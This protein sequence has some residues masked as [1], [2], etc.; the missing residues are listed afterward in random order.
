M[1]RRTW[2]HTALGLLLVVAGSGC[3]L[4]AEVATMKNYDPSD[5]VGAEV[6]DLALR[7]V[8][9]IV[10]DMGTANLVMSVVNT[11]DQEIELQVQYSDRGVKSNQ[12]IS[13]SGSAGLTKI[14][15]NPTEGLKFS[16]PDVVAG[17]LAP[18]YFQYSNVPGALILVPVLDGALSE[19]EL[20]V[21]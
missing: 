6:G 3:T 20:L 14:G 9:L 5:G 16:G 1:N 12:F 18:L 2:L 7:N 8:M 17:G 4:T 11:G 19:Y 21:P 13:I 15:D 10:N